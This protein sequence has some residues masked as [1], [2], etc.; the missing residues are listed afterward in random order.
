MNVPIEP[1]GISP[2]STGTPS[3]ATTSNW[4]RPWMCSASS[5]IVRRSTIPA[6]V[7]I[8]RR[9][10]CSSGTPRRPDIFKKV[11]IANRGEI[12]CRIGSTLRRLGVGLV[13]V[14]SDADR[15][16]RPVLDA[17]ESGSARPRARR[18][19]LFRID[20]ILAACASRRRGGPS[21]LWILQ[22]EWRVRRTARGRR[23]RV[24]RPETRPYARFRPQTYRARDLRAQRRPLASGL[25]PARSADEAVE[26]AARIGYPVMLKSTAG[27]GGIGMHVRWTRRSRER[28]ESVQ[29]RRAQTLA[30]TGFIS[31]VSSPTRAISK[32]R[33]SA[34]ARGA[35]SRS[36]SA[37][38][39]CSGAIRR[40]SRR[41][42][43][44][45]S[46]P[47]MRERLHAAAVA[48]CEASPTG[49]LA[50]SSSSTI[51]RGTI[52][53]SSRSTRGFRSNIR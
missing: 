36:A 30:T 47:A 40:S 5:R 21:G 39:R 28:F 51:S 23:P 15:C 37:I 32:C 18:A 25:R 44:R 52:S 53:I 22:R 26:A 50:R 31:S 3:P 29:R 43:R 20:A 6:T 46:Q 35:P 27:G 42:L 33:F 34:T 9:F 14:Y 13:A 45:G 2:S 10:G 7:S 41:R 16:T 24:H 38:V 11:L 12:A 17:D 48:L 4:L 1:W 8:R 19:K 49:R